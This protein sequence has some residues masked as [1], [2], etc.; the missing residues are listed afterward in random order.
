M[1]ASKDTQTGEAKAELG[2]QAYHQNNLIDSFNIKYRLN[3]ERYVPWYLGS[4]KEGLYD[5]L[6]K[7]IAP[8]HDQEFRQTTTSGSAPWSGSSTTRR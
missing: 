3:S 2:L 1:V 5:M 8:E 4:R 6:Y 7:P